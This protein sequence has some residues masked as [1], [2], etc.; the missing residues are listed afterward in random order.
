MKVLVT[1]GAGYLGSVL[2][3]TLLDVGYKV[4][5]LDN[6]MHGVNS[7]KQYENDAN[8]Q[9]ILGNKVI[10]EDCKKALRNCDVLVDLAAIVGNV[11]CNE[12]P[13]F[14]MRV[15]YD[16][17]LKLLGIADEMGIEKA[18][19]ASTCSVYENSEDEILD[20]TSLTSPKT[21]YARSK[22]LAEE[23]ILNFDSSI[24]RVVLRLATL[25]GPSLR[26]RFDLVL[27]KMTVDALERGEIIVEGGDQ[28]R[29][30]FDVRDAA[31]AILHLIEEESRVPQIFNIGANEGNYQIEKLAHSVTQKIPNL[32]INHIPMKIDRSYKVSFSKLKRTGFET[33]YSID[34]TIMAIQDYVRNN[35]IGS[36]KNPIYH[37]R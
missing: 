33:L 12:N 15:N 29:P 24:T 14:C 6:I 10:D 17:S 35:I 31:R 16:A 37:N 2:V 1:G 20:E 21:H 13:E 8:F 36:S 28:W 3:G 27:N 26:M 9:F 34:D 23:D 19:Y 25:S 32:A 7:L 5:V 18:F 11:A 30:V 4:R 22:I